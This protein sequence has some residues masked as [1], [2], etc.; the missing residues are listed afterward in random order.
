MDSNS[1]PKSC[2]HAVVQFPTEEF[3]SS[4]NI[5]RPASR[6]CCSPPV[7]GGPVATHSAPATT[8]LVQAASKACNHHH[9]RPEMMVNE[10]VPT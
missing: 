5:P 6:K 9:M 7:Q 1:T 4:R 8:K 2:V 3:S 10:R